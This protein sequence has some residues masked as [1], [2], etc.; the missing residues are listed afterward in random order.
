M[1]KADKGKSKG[2]GKD[3]D[4]VNKK[5]LV[6]SVDRDDD[7][8]RKTGI[9]GPI[10]GRENVLDAAVK[11]GLADPSDSDTNVLFRAVQ[12]R[13]QWEPRAKKIEVAAVTGHEKVGTE[14][15][16]RIGDQLD[17]ILKKF[18]ADGVILVTD[19]REDEFIE[20]VI[21]SKTEIISLDRIIVQ[22]SEELETTYFILHEYLSN[23]MEDR[24]VSG[25][26]F[27]LPGLWLMSFCI[28]YYYKRFE[29]LYIIG[30]FTGFYIFS[31]GFGID[32]ILSEELAPGRFSIFTYL[33]A[34]LLALVGVFNIWEHAAGTW[35]D[36]VL[37][38]VV[39]LYIY[40]NPWAPLAVLV[41]LAGK[42]ID[43]YAHESDAEK[44]SPSEGISVMWYYLRMW[45]FAISLFFMLYQVANHVVGTISLNELYMTA[46][47]AMFFAL[48]IWIIS[49]R[50][51]GKAEP[52]KEGA[53][54]G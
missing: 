30:G 46:A 20:P 17:T 27:G 6:L 21:R 31:K 51:E 44:E 8:G 14:S 15:D 3:K 7:L 9:K 53:A 39:Q 52:K 37:F 36:I 19:G 1:S 35:Q 23:L 29:I 34:L 26:I 32:K 2:K 13:D 24:R 28:A 42:T 48:A 47:V 41:A 16:L 49:Y 11:L 5:I 43:A 22:Q 10:T 38:R 25:L 40:A 18:K 4:K 50:Q 54:R 45:G 12:M 33:A